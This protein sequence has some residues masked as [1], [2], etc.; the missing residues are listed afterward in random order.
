MTDTD[1]SSNPLARP[2]P[3]QRT[4]RIGRLRGDLLFVVSAIGTALT[5]ISALQNTL[6]VASWAR[7]LVDSFQSAA[8]S[9]WAFALPWLSVSPRPMD[10]LFLNMA[11][12]SAIIALGS[13]S[14]RAEVPKSWRELNWRTEL[15]ALLGVSL[16]TILVVWAGFSSIREHLDGAAGKQF[17]DAIQTAKTVEQGEAAAFTYMTEI[18]AFVPM[19]DKFS[20]AVGLT[21]GSLQERLP[22]V[23]LLLIVLH[24]IL[25]AAPSLIIFGAGKLFGLRGDSRKVS[26][27][28]WLFLALMAAT[29]LL[30]GLSA[31][32]TEMC[33]GRSDGVQ[34]QLCALIKKSTH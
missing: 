25:I 28:A 27:W 16:V 11:A 8:A 10:V 29:L 34:N 18:S 15:L 22:G 17:L 12:F 32:W 6:T 7:A 3:A 9:F 30:S 20:Q 14:P 21:N 19:V 23:I 13:L 33:S 31:A 2:E 5:A 1:N 4:G 26:R 24:S